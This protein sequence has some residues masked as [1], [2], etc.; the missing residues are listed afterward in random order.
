MDYLYPFRS[1]S[2]GHPIPEIK[3]FQ[4]LT[5]ILEG[6]GHG[7]DQRPGSYGQ[8][9]IILIRFFLFHINQTSNSRDRAISK[10]DV[11][12]PKVKVMSE[13]KGQGHIV[14]PVSNRFR[15]ISIKPN[16]LEI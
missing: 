1:M 9:S 14:Y 7:C 8:P 4:T 15:F 16:V 12:T 11:Q 13:V 2:T 3:L 6:H 5:L 10:Y